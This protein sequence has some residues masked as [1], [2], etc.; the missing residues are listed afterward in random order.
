MYN[1]SNA[2][3]QN[4][5]KRCARMFIG[6]YITATNHLKNFVTHFRELRAPSSQ[7]KILGTFEMGANGTEIALESFRRNRTLLN[8]R[9]ANHSSESS[10]NSSRT[11]IPDKKISE[12]WIL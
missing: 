1:A 3:G 11:E 5:C 2:M 8:F 4:L 12:M 7:P 10:G 9:R 6:Q